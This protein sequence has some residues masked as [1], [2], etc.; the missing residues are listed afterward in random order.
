[1]E[2]S[3]ANGLDGFLL[4]FSSSQ[5]RDSL[6]K[7]IISKIKLNQRILRE[8]FL[9]FVLSINVKIILFIEKSNDKAGI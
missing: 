4:Y 3:L 9:N 2:E 8:G 5:L 6:I 7:N 1:M